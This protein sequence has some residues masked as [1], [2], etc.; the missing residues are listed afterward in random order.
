MSRTACFFRRG[1]PAKW[2]LASALLSACLV[3]TLSG[4]T[5]PSA[6]ASG[7]GPGGV[8]PSPPQTKHRTTTAPPVDLISL[9]L[10]VAVLGQASSYTVVVTSPSG[11]I[12]ATGTTNAQGMNQLM[13]PAMIGL[14]LDVLDTTVVGLPVAGGQAILITIP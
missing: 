12:V 3:V 14:E 6:L 9:P 13:V 10:H 7:G 4:A 5:L 8:D 2:M 11:S 1:C